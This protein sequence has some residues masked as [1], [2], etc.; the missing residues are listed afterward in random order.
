MST[1]FTTN[2]IPGTSGLYDFADKERANNHYMLLWLRRTQQLFKWEGLPDSIPENMLELYLQLYGHCLILDHEGTLYASFGNWGGNMDAYYR[3]KD[4]V[5]ANP[6][7]PCEKTFTLGEGCELAYNDS[8]YAGIASLLNRYSS[9][10]VETD[11]T[12]RK[13]LV[14]YIVHKL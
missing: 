13:A 1:I 10:M 6:Y 11:L 3:P 12:M 5:I 8:L 2:G 9:M 14:S 7:I 4:Y